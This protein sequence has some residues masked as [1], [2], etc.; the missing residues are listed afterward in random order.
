MV[1]VSQHECICILFVYWVFLCSCWVIL[2]CCLSVSASVPELLGS[3][4]GGLAALNI[5]YSH[6]TEKCFQVIETNTC[7]LNIH[8]TW[9]VRKYMKENLVCA[10]KNQCLKIN[11]KV[12]FAC[13]C[14][15]IYTYRIPSTSVMCL[16][17][18]VLSLNEDI[19]WRWF[20]ICFLL[21]DETRLLN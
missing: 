18:L 21:I 1:V 17:R 10:C 20:E 14:L 3:Q 8:T 4:T 7:L 12:L 6:E 19:S 16:L 5:E 13:S 9:Y 2:D 11:A 15:N